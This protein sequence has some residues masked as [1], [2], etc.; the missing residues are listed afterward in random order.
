MVHGQ[1]SSQNVPQ[2]TMATDLKC[3]RATCCG[4]LPVRPWLLVTQ[5]AAATRIASPFSLLI[6][7]LLLFLLLFYLLFLSLDIESSDAA[8][9]PTYSEDGISGLYMKQWAVERGGRRRQKLGGE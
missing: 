6:S 8:W 9:F 7:P 3:A 5:H 4:S 1:A 2:T